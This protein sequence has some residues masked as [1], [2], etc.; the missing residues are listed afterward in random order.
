MLLWRVTEPC[1]NHGG[2]IGDVASCPVNFGRRQQTATLINLPHSSFTVRQYTTVKE[3]R[4]HSERGKA[5]MTRVVGIV[6]TM[7]YCDTKVTVLVTS[8]VRAPC[9]RSHAL[10]WWNVIWRPSPG[11]VGRD[12]TYTR[13]RGDRAR[14]CLRPRPRGSGESRFGPEA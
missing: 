10:I 12:G 7:P 8:W 13:G 2:R 3:V 5:T 14:R 11:G 4:L 6:A 9:V 1:W